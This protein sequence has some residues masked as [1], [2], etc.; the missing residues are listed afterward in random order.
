MMC[1]YGHRMSMSSRI[2]TIFLTSHNRE[3][4][5]SGE[6]NLDPQPTPTGNLFSVGDWVQFEPEW[7]TVSADIQHQ[8]QNSVIGRIW[9][10][11]RD[12]TIDAA[13]VGRELLVKGFDPGDGD[14]EKCDG[15]REGQFVRPKPHIE[16]SRGSRFVW[17]GWED[18]RVHKVAWSMARWDGP[19]GRGYF[20][21]LFCFWCFHVLNVSTLN[22]HS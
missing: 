1:K 11:R 16:A 20:L 14:I 4:G 8:S 3:L 22:V 2:P 10:I 13:V 18:G 5:I 6:A 17:A 7:V 9:A 15:F 21:C 12:G 19:T